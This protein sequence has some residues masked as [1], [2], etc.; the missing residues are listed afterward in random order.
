MAKQKR[1][2]F[3][4]G[5]LACL[6]FLTGFGVTGYAAADGDAVSEEAADSA[7]E[8]GSLDKILTA[9]SYTEYLAKHATAPAGKDGFAVDVT[10][11]DKDSTT[12][13]DVKVLSEY[14]GEKD[15]IFLP[16]KGAVGW[17][18]KVP[19]TGMYTVLAAYYAGTDGKK[20]SIERTVYIDGEIPYYESIYLSLPK[21]Y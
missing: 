18:I 14:E 4:S 9:D 21:T 11:Y 16:S 5:A 17:K 13:T 20:T 10:K 6:T 8:V 15:V 7:Y 12:A 3:L 1:L 19:S 2:R